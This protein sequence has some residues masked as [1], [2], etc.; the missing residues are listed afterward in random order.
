VQSVYVVKVKP[1]DQVMADEFASDYF[2]IIG[3][4]A[5]DQAAQTQEEWEERR[6]EAGKPLRL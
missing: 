6:R 4:M 3:S 1:R 2:E 5:G